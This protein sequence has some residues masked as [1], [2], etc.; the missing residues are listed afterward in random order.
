MREGGSGH[1]GRFF[2]F[3]ITSP[4]IAIWVFACITEDFHG[5]GILLW[6]SRYRRIIAPPLPVL[7]RHIP[8]SSLGFFSFTFI[9]FW[10]WRRGG[11]EAELLTCWRGRTSRSGGH[12]IPD[13]RSSWCTARSS[14]QEVGSPA[15]HTHTHRL[16]V[17]VSETQNT[18][19]EAA[20]LIHTSPSH[21]HH[22]ELKG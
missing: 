17:A 16:H 7:P 8:A 22:E 10:T 15:A 2:F 1:D 9:A 21:I 12:L 11:E 5:P 19:L 3:L 13:S 18:S 20:L 4:L 14:P 6:R